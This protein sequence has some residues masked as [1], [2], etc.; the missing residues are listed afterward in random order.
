[1]PYG[2]LIPVIS[3]SFAR[4]RLKSGRSVEE[5]ASSDVDTTALRETFLSALAKGCT[6]DK[7]TLLGGVVNNAVKSTLGVVTPQ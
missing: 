1:M 5:H 6:E 2:S 7:D 3:I 4:K